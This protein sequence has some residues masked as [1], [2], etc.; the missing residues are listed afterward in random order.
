MAQER[1]EGTAYSALITQITTKI[2]YHNIHLFITYVFLNFG[3]VAFTMKIPLKSV[4][5]DSWPQVFSLSTREH[6]KCKAPLDPRLTSEPSCCEVTH[7]C[8]RVC[9]SAAFFILFH[10]TT[11]TF[12]PTF[13]Y[14]TI[15]V[16]YN[17][18]NKKKKN[19]FIYSFSACTSYSTR[20][21]R[22]VTFY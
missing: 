11:S 15:S 22:A 9:K 12:N 4:T 3:G 6:K 16:D 10:S 5:E 13:S 17:Y 19:H 2:I 7:F 21:E 20:P 1:S 14:S 8:Q 18:N